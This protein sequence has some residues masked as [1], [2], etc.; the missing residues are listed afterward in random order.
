MILAILQARMSSTRLPGKVLKPAL[1]KPIL[2][3]QIDRV[4]LSRRI[5]RL[6]LATSVNADDDPLEELAEQAG[7]GCFRGSLD[8]VLERFVTCARSYAP[9]HVVRLTGDC[10]VIDA[11]VIDAV[12]DQH[13]RVGADYTS[14]FLR[15]TFPDGLDT[16]V[17]KMSALETAYREATT[18]YEIEHVTP[19]LYQHPERFSLSS[20]EHPQDHSKVRWTLDTEAD[21][22]VLKALIERMGTPHFDWM[23]LLNHP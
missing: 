11:T 13:L 3:F 10:P 8:H 21:Y 20:H 9:D 6:V 5:D 18:R 2:L 16:E 22:G 4:R 15:R 19:F 23:D 17:M 14:N 7:I 12:I 1:G